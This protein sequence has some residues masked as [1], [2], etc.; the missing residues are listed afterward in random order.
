MFDERLCPPRDRY[1]FNVRR[2]HT[3]PLLMRVQSCTCCRKIVGRA[4]RG[5]NDGAGGCHDICFGRICGSVRRIANPRRS[6]PLVRSPVH[7]GWLR[8]EVVIAVE[9]TSEPFAD[10]PAQLILPVQPPDERV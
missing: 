6:K 8:G 9:V 5:S 1:R 4:N 3:A 10:L 2:L 7:F